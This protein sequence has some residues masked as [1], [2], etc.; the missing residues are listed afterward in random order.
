VSIPSIEEILRL[1]DL[2]FSREEILASVA[3]SAPAQASAPVKAAK[4]PT[5]KKA[6]PKGKNSFYSAV[7][8]SR[9]PCAYGVAKCGFFA[10][11]GVGSKQHST[12]KRGLA[13]MRAAR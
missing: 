3:E 2:G 5:A 11:K 12:C 13:A 6:S 8:A 4:P 9:V 7:I 1:A 10:P